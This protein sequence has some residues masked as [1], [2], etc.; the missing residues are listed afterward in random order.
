M[1][2]A[3][4]I[5]RSS[6]ISILSGF[7]HKWWWVSNILSRQKL[8]LYLVSKLW[9]IWRLQICSR[10]IMNFVPILALHLL[11]FLAL[12]LHD[13]GELFLIHIDFSIWNFEYLI[14]WDVSWNVFTPWLHCMSSCAWVVTR[15]FSSFSR[16][17]SL[18]CNSLV[19]PA[20]SLWRL[21]AGFLIYIC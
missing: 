19:L 17:F 9:H 21:L 13:L 12:V 1:S 3:L 10:L 14:Q 8:T 11:L 18:G 2:R 5:G 7:L 16:Q 20:L 6:F 4:S 15:W